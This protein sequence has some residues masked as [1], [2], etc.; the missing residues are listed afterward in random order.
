MKH[1][2]KVGGAFL[3]LL[4]LA[5]KTYR[6]RDAKEATK[7]AEL[8][9]EIISAFQNTNPRVKASHINM[10]IHRINRM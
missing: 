9:K 5:V 2:L 6:A 1:W 3:A 4:I 8:A 10:L 7:Q